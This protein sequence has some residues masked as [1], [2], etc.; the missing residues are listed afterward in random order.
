MR[1]GPKLFHLVMV[2]AYLSVGS[3]L[4]F[5][6]WFPELQGTLRTVLGIAF[7]L[8]ALYRAYLTLFPKNP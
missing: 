4:L 3:I 2:L 5:S 7:L 6:R 8:Y 1:P